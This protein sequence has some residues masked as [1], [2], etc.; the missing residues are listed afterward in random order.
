M[1]E[2]SPASVMPSDIPIIDMYP[3][4]LDASGE[5]NRNLFLEDGLHPNTAG[6]QLMARETASLISSKSNFHP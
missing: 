1:S 4:F 6:H 2:K 5:V 3:L